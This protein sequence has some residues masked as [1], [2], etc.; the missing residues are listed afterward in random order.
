MSSYTPESTSVSLLERVKTRDPEAWRRLVTLY[1]P[2][3]YGWCR[4][5]GLQVADTADVCQEVFAAV[6]AS[7]T[8]FRRDRPDDSF[9]AWLWTISRNKIMDHF[10]RRQKH[11][12]PEGGTDAQ[13]L[14]AQIPDELP[15][16]SSSTD[17]SFGDAGGLE[18]RALE[19]LRSE[20]EDRTWQA[21][22]R[23]AVDGQTAAEI[24]DDLG[25]TKKAVR[26]AK[27]RVV[28]RL[29]LELDGLVD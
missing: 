20:F 25:M 6:A 2:L 24:A 19:L 22:W 21:F 16:S 29:R 3:V 4:K 1:G 26:Q 15:A 13:Q 28:R 5:S 18:R 14:F 11:A 9:R 27:F 10:R 12:Q 17:S 7:M 23:M 8:K